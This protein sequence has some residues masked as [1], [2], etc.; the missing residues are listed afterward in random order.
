MRRRTVNFEEEVHRRVL[1]HKERLLKQGQD[2]SFS[3]IVNRALKEVLP[4]GG[5]E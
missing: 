1:A 2:L 4:K 5:Q 3:A